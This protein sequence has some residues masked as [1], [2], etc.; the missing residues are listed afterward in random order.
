MNLGSQFKNGL[1]YRLFKYLDPQFENC[2]LF[3]SYIIIS[4]HICKLTLFKWNLTFLK[5]K[6]KNLT[7]EVNRYTYENS[8]TFY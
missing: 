7:K 2:Q 5:K 1:S 6:K 4:L 8:D 3:E